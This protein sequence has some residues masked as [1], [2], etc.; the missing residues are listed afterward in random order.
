MK[1]SLKVIQT[2]KIEREK[3]YDVQHFRI[4]TADHEQNIRT[5]VFGHNFTMT[6]AFRY[7]IQKTISRQKFQLS[8]E[9]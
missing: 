8:D 6:N 5:H 7:N 2:L 4:E 3:T 9:L 1:F